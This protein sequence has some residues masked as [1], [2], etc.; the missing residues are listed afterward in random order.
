MISGNICMPASPFS[1]SMPPRLIT[2][3]DRLL[4]ATP[5]ELP[6][7]RD[8]LK[9]HRSTLTPKLWTVLESAKPGDAESASVRQRPGKLRPG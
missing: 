4:E 1:P 3:S 5:S 9:A 7:L 8:A 2:S 6:V